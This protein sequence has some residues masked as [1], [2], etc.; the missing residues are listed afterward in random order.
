MPADTQKKAF[1]TPHRSRR[2]KPTQLSVITTGNIPLSASGDL[3]ET[4]TDAEIA[5]VIAYLGD[6][7][8]EI[9]GVA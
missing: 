5:L 1:A 3:D 2:P 9:L 6:K 7:L 8:A 4:V